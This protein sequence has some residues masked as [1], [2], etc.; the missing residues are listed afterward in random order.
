M[1]PKT[2]L[3]QRLSLVIVALVLTILPAAAYYN[4]ANFMRITVVNVA[5]DMKTNVAYD[6]RETNVPHRAPTCYSDVAEAV[7]DGTDSSLML[8]F[9]CAVSGV[10][11]TISKDGS[12]VLSETYTELSEGDACTFAL[13]QYGAGEYE[14]KVTAADLDNE[15]YCSFTVK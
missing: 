13:A 4:A 9:G 5:Y 15:L 7:F 6:E 10:T 14:V 12:E 2:N 3:K 1:K 8:E 11:I